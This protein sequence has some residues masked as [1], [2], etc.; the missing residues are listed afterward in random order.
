[1]MIKR[2]ELL[3][4]MIQIIINFLIVNFDLSIHEKAVLFCNNLFRTYFRAC[5]SRSETVKNIFL[6]LVCF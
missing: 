2:S 6:L 4:L 3:I 5:S 1:M